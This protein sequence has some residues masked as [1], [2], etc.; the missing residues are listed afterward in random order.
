MSSFVF[1]VCMVL[2]TVKLYHFYAAMYIINKTMMYFVLYSYIIYAIMVK[3]YEVNF[4]PQI[5]SFFTPLAIWC[6]LAF[7]L[8]DFLFL[9]WGYNDSRMDITVTIAKLL[10][11]YG[12]NP[13]AKSTKRQTA[14]MLALAK[15]RF[16]DLIV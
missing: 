14:I 3:R 16:F 5:L 8:F 12:C 2:Y 1:Y 15:V 11:K 7:S 9:Q 4:C 13:K 6:T 10:I